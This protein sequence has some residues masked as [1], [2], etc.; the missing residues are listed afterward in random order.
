[1][2]IAK[3]GLPTIHCESCVKV[4]ELTLKALKGVGKRQY[5]VA[6]RSMEARFDENAIGAEEIVNAIK[7]DAGYEAVLESEEDSD[8]GE[9]GSEGIFHSNPPTVLRDIVGS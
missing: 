9:G 7:N 5:D 2:K 8:D 4:I 3:I 1:M 6:G